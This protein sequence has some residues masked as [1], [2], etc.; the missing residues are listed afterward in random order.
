MLT[1]F[2]SV[3]GNSSSKVAVVW[4]GWAGLLAAPVRLFALLSR[5]RVLGNQISQWLLGG[6]KLRRD[7]GKLSRC[8]IDVSFEIFIGLTQSPLE[9]EVL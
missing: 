6:Q 8:K 7:S 1:W 9:Y 2:K 3:C 4:G 5:T